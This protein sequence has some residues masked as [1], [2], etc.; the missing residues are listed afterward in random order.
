M[1]KELIITAIQALNVERIETTV[2][3]I[4]YFKR[5]GS[6]PF[7]A[8]ENAEKSLGIFVDFIN[9]EINSCTQT[10][11]VCL[12]L[13]NSNK[14]VT[15]L[16]LD[17]YFV[18][19]ILNEIKNNITDTQFEIVCSKVLKY[20]FGIENA[21][22]T[23]AKSDGG[24]DFFGSYLVIGGKDNHTHFVVEVI[25]QS[26][27]YGGNISRPEIEKFL[28]FIQKAQ[29]ERKHNPT[30]YIF[31]TTSDYSIEAFQLAKSF[32]II[33]WN[34]FQIASFIFNSLTS[35]YNSPQECIHAYLNN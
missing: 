16:N 23:R 13:P 18:T 29:V 33:C 4:D 3:L 6:N 8:A 28:G 5:A 31:A 11:E 9:N 30:A 20:S 21:N 32:G 17:Y 26:K 35:K 19:G 2:L 25:G 27:Q 24:L 22:V 10:G 1:N 15:L 12:F 7:R 14:N 34:G